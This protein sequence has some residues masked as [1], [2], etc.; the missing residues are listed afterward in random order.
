MDDE[1]EITFGQWVYQYFA[2][3]IHGYCDILLNRID[4]IFHDV[5]GEQE[6]AAQEFLHSIA[7]RS[8]EDDDPSEVYEAAY[9]H[10][11]ERAMQFVE[12]RTVFLATGVSGLFHLF[13]KQ[14]YRHINK[15]LKDW[16][17]EPIS[18]WRD[19]EKMIPKF[20]QRRRHGQS[21]VLINAFGNDDLQELMNVAN[22]IKHGDDGSAYKKLKASNAV[23][24]SQNRLK[25]DGTV[26]PYAVFKASVSIQREDV[27][28]YRNALLQFWK[29]EG[30]YFAPRSAF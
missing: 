7:R 24:V 29:I 22:V 6:R 20:V 17:N 11:A 21:H 19:L 2:P 28:R 25:N 4:P 1:L 9:E 14:L 18:Q 15:E 8:H 16:L 30:T 26:G 12:M 3:D 13:E 10:A 27:E 23:V 5:K